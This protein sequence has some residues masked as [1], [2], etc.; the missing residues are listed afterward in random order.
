MT[1]PALRA[2]YFLGGLRNPLI[3]DSHCLTPVTAHSAL[4]RCQECR[5][6]LLQGRCKKTAHSLDKKLTWRPIAA[7]DAVARFHADPSVQSV[8]REPVLTDRRRVELFLKA[9]NTG[10]L[11]D[12]EWHLLQK[13]TGDEALPAPKSP[14]PP[15]L[16]ELWRDVLSDFVSQKPGIRVSQA[17]GQ[18][19]CMVLESNV[20]GALRAEMTTDGKLEVNFQILSGDYER[21]LEYALLLLLASNRPFARDLCMCRMCGRFFLVE[22]VR[23]GRPRREFCNRKHLKRFHEKTGTER[24]RR[25]RAERAEAKKLRMDIDDYREMKAA[26]KSPEQWKKQRRQHK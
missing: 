5:Y 4:A 13:G 3:F 20:V 11:S 18:S 7:N 14:V 12:D 23:K 9:L 8:R 17:F 19:L 16:R 6:S 21:G 15:E 25:S 24:V 2:G 26:G 10:A 22:P 1:Q